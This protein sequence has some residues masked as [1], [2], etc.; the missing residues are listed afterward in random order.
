[1]KKKR[2]PRRPYVQLWESPYHGSWM[3]VL[4]EEATQPQEEEEEANWSNTERYQPRK[5]HPF[6][7]TRYFLQ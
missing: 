3:D 2:L 1:M 4:M 6:D 5:V 7:P